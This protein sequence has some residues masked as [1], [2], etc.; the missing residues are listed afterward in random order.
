MYFDTLPTRVVAEGETGIKN[1]SYIHDESKKGVKNQDQL[2]RFVLVK[3][4]IPKEAA[5][6]F[7]LQL[8]DVIVVII[9]HQLL[10][11][12]QNTSSRSRHLSKGAR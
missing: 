12:T 5:D 3:W 1:M 9:S 8:Q 4:I 7:C 2:R 10:Y 11:F 6:E